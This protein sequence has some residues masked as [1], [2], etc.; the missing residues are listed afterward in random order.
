VVGVIPEVENAVE[1]LAVAGESVEISVGRRLGNGGGGLLLST[2][3]KEVPLPASDRWLSRRLGVRNP[4]IETRLG[5]RNPAIETRALDLR[6]AET[7]LER[8]D[9]L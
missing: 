4:A 6:F 3:L 8:F 1:L 7:R 5:V 9:E 2:L